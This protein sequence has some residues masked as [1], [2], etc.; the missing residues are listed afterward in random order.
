MLKHGAGEACYGVKVGDLKKIQKRVKKDHS[1]ALA[2][3]DTGVH[4]ARYLAC[5][6]VDDARMTE[7]D[8]DRWV[9]QATEV[10]AGTV[11]SWVAAESPHGAA[12]ARRWIDSDVPAV[13]G[14]GWVTW[15]C[16]VAL[17]PD[18][19]LDM[20]ELRKLLRRVES[21]LRAAPNRVRYQMNTF[22]ISVGC[23]V[24]ALKED[25]LKTAAAIGTV[26]VDMGETACQ[27]PEAAAYIRKVEA[28]GRIGKKRKTVKC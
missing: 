17:K 21:T 13:A 1:L 16:L 19:E 5:L 4:D 23:Y 14:A 12:V 10:L 3:Y 24:A 27:V 22:V 6:I 11:V 20:S 26:D 25:A 8:L 18:D 9:G 7:A 2:L 15:A 28:M